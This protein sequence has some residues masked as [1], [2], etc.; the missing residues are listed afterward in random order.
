MART[1]ILL[2]VLS[3]FLTTKAQALTIDLYD[4]GST[5]M[6]GA[7]MGAFLEAASFWEDNLSDPVTVV[8][9]IEFANLDSGILGSTRS[10]RTT[11]SYVTVR[12]AM[13]ADAFAAA[14]QNAL[15][16]LPTSSLPIVATQG[17]R[18]EASVTLTTANAKA[19]GIG[20]GLDSLY[21]GPLP[22]SA[23]AR[24]Q[25]ANAFASTFDYDRSNGISSGKTD[26][27]SVAAHEIGHALGFISMTDV[28]D[29]NANFTLHP[30][31]FDFWRFA[32]TGGPH[33]LTS[34][35]RLC[36]AGAAEYYDSVK[37]NVSLSHGVSTSDSV[38]GSSSGSCQASHWSDHLGLLMDPTL[39]AGISVNPQTLDKHALDY[40]GY[41]HKY[42]LL[43]DWRKW[44]L[45][46]KFPDFPWRDP[47]LTCPPEFGT[48]DPKV[49]PVLPVGK[50][51]SENFSSRNFPSRDLGPN[52]S[53]Q[54]GADFGV[55]GLRNRGLVGW[56]LFQDATKR[57]GGRL[58]TAPNVRGEQNLFPAFPPVRVL[59][60]AI[61]AFEFVSD[62]KRGASFRFT[63][64]L[65]ESGAPFD[66]LLG[67]F[68]GFSITGFVDG[69]DDGVEGDVD[70]LLS[71][72]L[73]AQPSIP[74]TRNSPLTY[75]IGAPGNGGS[76]QIVDPKALGV[77]EEPIRTGKRFIRGDSNSDGELDMADPVRVLDALFRGGAKIACDDAA[78][79]NDDGEVELT[80]AVYVLR[81]LFL[82]GAVPAGAPARVVQ[83][84]ATE[85]GLGCDA[86]L[87][88]AAAAGPVDSPTRR[89][90]TPKIPLDVKPIPI[91]IPIPMPELFPGVIPA[92]VREPIAQPVGRLPVVRLPAPRLK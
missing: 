53:F 37:N 8:V 35:S 9:N 3:A 21:G 26:F 50:F 69:A 58:K 40:I 39:G 38:C 22:N 49:Y 82:G 64:T 65:A 62:E 67:E 4:T 43:I 19:L 55:D 83:E 41:S 80:D 18:N 56:A 59:P 54:M 85:D 89:V 88:E 52:M 47:C 90:P 6:N 92:P 81:F 7:Q 27:V 13:L 20:T 25:F 32:E 57:V 91:P 15:N 77:E 51:P 87:E 71:F 42:K 48:I 28:Q 11:N 86:P 29:L 60:P 1:L 73:L 74:G 30:N 78:D 68:G 5:P 76:F 61:L 63:D 33:N 23:D 24:I 44:I 17:E 84:D 2:V 12:A 45:V 79:A 70:G 75:V 34:E 10:Q 14:E 46:W 72:V 36:T 16:Q 31:T 66:P